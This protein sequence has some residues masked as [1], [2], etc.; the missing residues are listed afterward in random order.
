MPVERLSRDFKDISMSFQVNPLNNDLISIKNETA[1]ARS[2]R[3][4]IF[5]LPGERFFNENLGSRVS[6][7]LFE[8]MDEISASV[9]KD[10]ITN[11]INNYEPRVDLISVDV[12]P[13]Y[14]NNE[15]QNFLLNEAFNND[16]S[17]EEPLNL[18]K[19]KS[20]ENKYKKK[21]SKIKMKNEN[22][23]KISKALKVIFED[24]NRFRNLPD[25]FKKDKE[26]VYAAIHIDSVVLKFADES[27][28]KDKPFI[29]QVV[30]LW[31]DVLKYAD[32]SLRKDESVVLKAAK[33]WSSALKFADQSL[34]KDKTVVTQA[35]KQNGNALEFADL[36][37]KKDESIALMAVKQD[38]GAL[39]FVHESLKK[40]IEEK[41]LS[42]FEK[43]LIINRKKFN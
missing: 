37:L 4:L 19:V 7:T 38:R 36:S 24:G 18:D 40:Y 13:N 22:R 21:E 35:V 8:N 28:K 34:K 41:M 10:E 33:N 20:Q 1:I 25:K 31:S 26:I 16:D 6:Q 42:I 2:V 15:L 29:L 32:I 17:I 27:L 9:I 14:D 23:K 30:G 12:S 39:R 3:N 5:T 43:R 11:T